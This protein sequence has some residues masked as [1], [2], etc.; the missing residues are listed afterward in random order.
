LLWDR[1]SVDAK[2]APFV[3]AHI[4]VQPGGILL[5]VSLGRALPSGKVCSTTYQGVGGSS[6]HDLEP[7]NMGYGTSVSGK[8]HGQSLPILGRAVTYVGR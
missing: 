8:T 2:Y 4:G 1:G 6:W 3:V 5:G 7:V